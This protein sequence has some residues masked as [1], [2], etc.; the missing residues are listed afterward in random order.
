MLMLCSCLRRP[1][2]LLNCVPNFGVIVHL[3]GLESN[4]GQ[5]L[6]QQTL[7]LLQK[8]LFLKHLVSSPAFNSVTL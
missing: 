5:R 4:K 2:K 6:H 1:V 3:N 8:T 7:S